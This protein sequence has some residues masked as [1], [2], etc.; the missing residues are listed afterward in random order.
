[1]VPE[2]H[3]KPEESRLPLLL[4][5]LEC[6]VS[7]YVPSLQTMAGK[8]QAQ[9]PAGM[10]S[11]LEVLKALKSL[12]E[13]HKALDKKRTSDGSLSRGEDLAQV[14]ELQEI[15][16]KKSREQSEMKDR[17]AALSA[18]ITELEKD[19]DTARKDLLKSK[20]I[21]VNLQRD[22]REA[23]AQKEDM[24]KR[25]TTLEKRYLAAQHEAISVHNLDD[26]LENEIAN[27]DSV[28]RQ[29]EDKGRRLQQCL[30]LAEE[31]LQQMLTEVEAELAQRVAALSKDSIWKKPV[32]VVPRAPMGQTTPVIQTP[33]LPAYLVQLTNQQ[34]ITCWDITQGFL[35]IHSISDY[36]SPHPTS[37]SSFVI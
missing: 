10:T 20:E 29:K 7:Q 15:I 37:C 35:S 6:L 30:E 14:I 13:H 28:H 31:K 33:S 11:G 18:H 17:L 25:I 23:M 9:S 36:T 22:V 27:K 19:L 26:K 3:L 2:L 8:W 4:E 5:H 34:G 12:F 24:E 1:M 16:R 32:K 21:N